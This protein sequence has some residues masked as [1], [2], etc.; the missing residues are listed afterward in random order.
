MEQWVRVRNERDRRLLKRLIEV[1]GETD[2]VNAVHNCSRDGAK[3]YLS[4]VCRHLGV[5]VQ[6]LLS[7]HCQPG[8]IGE[9]HLQAIDRILQRPRTDPERVA[10]RR[11]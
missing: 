7:Q 10:N 8:R 6:T 2:I 5:S 9:Q 3:P 4:T 11:N 1:V